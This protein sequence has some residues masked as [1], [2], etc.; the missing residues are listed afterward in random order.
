MIFPRCSG[1]LLHVT[2]LPA[3]HGIG[4]LGPAAHDFVDFLAESGQTVWQVLPLSPTGYDDSPYQCFSAFAGNPLLIDLLDLQEQGWLGPQDLVVAPQLATDFVDYGKAIAFK[5]ALLR[6]AAQ[7]FFINA[8]ATDSKAFKTFCKENAEWLDDYALFMAGKDLHNGV[9]WTEWDAG[10]RRRDP[11]AL[12][13]WRQKL[14]PEIEVHKFAQF[15][16]FR[17]WENLKNRCRR[18]GIRTMAIS[19]LTLPMTAP[20]C[21]LIPNCFVWTSTVNPMWWQGFLLITSARPASSGEL[22]SIDG[23]CWQAPAIDGGS[24]V[25]GHR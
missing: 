23:T 18:R 15:E 24:I 16:F 10:L 5:Q 22:P 20:T 19:L 11:G 12:P 7:D 25:F 3:A 2:S 13:Q 14:S 17:Q 21:G 4:D 9:V 1:I 6:K 8:N